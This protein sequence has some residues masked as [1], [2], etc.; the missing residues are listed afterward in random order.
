[1]FK[2]I[3]NKNI[4][5]ITLFIIS[6]HLQGSGPLVH[7][8]HHPP[9]TVPRRAA[10]CG[11]GLA[12]DG[13]QPT[14]LHERGGVGG[15]SGRGATRDQH[16]QPTRDQTAP[17]R[18]DA[19]DEAG[20]GQA[21]RRRREDARSEEPDEQQVQ[22]QPRLAR[23]GRRPSVVRVVTP[24]T[25]P[26]SPQLFSA[27]SCVWACVFGWAALSLSHTHSHTHARPR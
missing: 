2:K 8:N 17:R 6:R 12:G 11:R 25:P 13:P 24:P 27:A 16:A 1:M 26:S 22:K 19:R 5:N 4:K 20:V 3:I 15:G 21:R 23:A 14:H 7:S 18:R 10:D 9:P